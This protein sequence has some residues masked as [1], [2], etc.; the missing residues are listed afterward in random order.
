MTHHNIGQVAARIYE[1]YGLSSSPPL[2]RAEAL[3]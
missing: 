2:Q 3:K 1:A